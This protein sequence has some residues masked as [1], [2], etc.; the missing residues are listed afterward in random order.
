[1]IEKMPHIAMDAVE[2]FHNIDRAFRKH[3]FYLSFLEKDPKFLPPEEPKSKRERRELKEREKEKKR[4]MKE[5]GLKKQR[6]EK[7]F[8]KTPV[9]VILHILSCLY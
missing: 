6:K 8:A 3:Y 9:E 1:M 7:T 4:I 2:Q 5:K